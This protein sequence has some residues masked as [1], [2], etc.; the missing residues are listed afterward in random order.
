[1]QKR[2]IPTII[3]VAYSVFVIKLLV[4]KMVSFKIGHLM[5]NFSGHATGPANFVP[6]KTILPYLMGAKGGVIAI[7]NIIGNIA[8]FVPIGFLVPFV[9][10]N[11]T[12]RKSLLLAV[13]VPLL[14]EII[15]VVFRVGIFDIDDVIL[16]GL[17]IMIG[18]WV[19]AMLRPK[20]T[21]VHQAST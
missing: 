16:N 5:F 3:L 17:G 2:L 12:W 14:I 9:Y 1:M 8:L 15:Q 7:F 4:F 18:Y 19:C 11:M 20:T 21:N 10:R 6:F 13:V